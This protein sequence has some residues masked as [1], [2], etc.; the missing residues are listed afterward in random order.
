M[1][2]N[3]KIIGDF[4][5]ICPE[6]GIGNPKDAENCLMCDKDLKNTIT[7]IEDDSYDLEIT[8]DSIILYKKKFWGAE[9]T[10]K[11]IQYYLNKMEKIEFG[12]PISR[13]IFVYEGKRIT[14][15]L[16]EENINILKSFF[17]I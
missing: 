12:S 2:S 17:K 16:R 15:P 11:I 10:G 3:E 5:F 4:S 1:S 7:F 13:F 8:K 14:F 6:C 9:R